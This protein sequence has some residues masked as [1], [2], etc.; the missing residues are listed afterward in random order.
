MGSDVTDARTAIVS[1]CLLKAAHRF[2]THPSGVAGLMQLLLAYGGDV[3]V[4]DQEGNTCLHILVSKNYY[5]SFDIL[6]LEKTLMLLLRGAD[7]NAR[8]Q[9]GH[10]NTPLLHALVNMHSE[11]NVLE[12]VKLFVK[13][14]ANVNTKNEVH[15]NSPLHEVVETGSL[16]LRN[17]EPFLEVLLDAGADVH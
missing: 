6:K 5:S 14:G 17:K 2:Q 12:A 16:H 13:H 15:G 8:S 1:D 7:I 9:E 3:N 4:R 11:S 10:G